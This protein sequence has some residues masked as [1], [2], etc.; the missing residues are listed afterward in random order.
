RRSRFLWRIAFQQEALQKHDSRLSRWR[1]RELDESLGRTPVDR[2]YR[3]TG[4]WRYTGI[5]T[6]QKNCPRHQT[7]RANGSKPNAATGTRTGVLCIL[8]IGRYRRLAYPG[9]ATSG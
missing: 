7:E 4:R 3:R 1:Y 2:Q 9:A 5:P 6:N 8:R